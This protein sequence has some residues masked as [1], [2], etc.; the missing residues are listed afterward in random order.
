MFEFV[1]QPPCPAAPLMGKDQRKRERV[2]TEP[3]VSSARVSSQKDGIVS[4]IPRQLVVHR[5]PLNDGYGSKTEADV[6]VIHE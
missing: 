3:I 4:S 6:G 1:P 5:S 2:R